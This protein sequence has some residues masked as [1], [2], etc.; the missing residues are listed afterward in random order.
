MVLLN[1][2]APFLYFTPL[3]FIFGLPI[4]LSLL[5]LCLRELRSQWVGRP[6]HSRLNVLLVWVGWS[7]PNSCSGICCRILRC[8]HHRLQGHRLAWPDGLWPWLRSLAHRSTQRH[9]SPN[10]R[11][12]L[13]R[14]HRAHWDKRLSLLHSS[15]LRLANSTLSTYAWGLCPRVLHLANWCLRPNRTGSLLRRRVLIIRPDL[16]RN[17]SRAACMCKSWLTAK[18]PHKKANCENRKHKHPLTPTHTRGRE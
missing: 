8:A 13:A 5:S 17:C 2:L 4:F 16:Q 6:R 18:P 1:A 7:L 10:D 3:L 9:C 15:M 14:R 12:R 11:A